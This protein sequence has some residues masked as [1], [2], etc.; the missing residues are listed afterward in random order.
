MDEVDGRLVGGLVV[1]AALADARSFGRAAER[2]GMT[3]SGVSK[4]IAKLEARLDARL[5]HRTSRAVELTEEGRALYERVAAHLAGIG[6]AAAETSKS[7]DAVRGRLRVNVDPLFSRMV[8]SPKLSEFLL[9]NPGMELRIETR[10][11]IA[12]LVSDGFDLAVRFGEPVPSALIARRVLDTRVLTVASPIYL[13]RHG[14]PL[15][16]RELASR[17]HQCI[18]AIDA[19]TGRPFD[20]EFRRGGEV[21]PVAVNGRLTVTDSGTK[22]GACLAGFGIA[23][24]I[25]LGLDDHLRS[26]ALIELFPDWPDERF[27]LYVYYASRNHVPAKVRRFID[28][29]TETLAA[30][31]HSP[32]KSAGLR[33]VG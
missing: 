11:R 26:G 17:D 20:W 28:F 14:R 27:P 4:A 5:V 32:R 31:S 25:D 8:L 7:R 19:S 3:Q 18:H 24:V 15:D 2:L 22:L 10:D 21:V 16:P 13:E 6:E 9:Q 33:K 30:K 12:D 29:I 1:L 23:Q